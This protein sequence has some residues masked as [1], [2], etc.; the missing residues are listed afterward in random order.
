MFVAATLRLV[1]I[2]DFL[3]QSPARNKEVEG[4]FEGLLGIVEE[5]VEA[6][7][8]GGSQGARRVYQAGKGHRHNL[9]GGIDKGQLVHVVGIG[10]VQGIIALDAAAEASDAAQIGLHV[11]APLGLRPARPTQLKTNRG[12][13]GEGRGTTGGRGVQLIA[14][15][16][17]TNAVVVHLVKII[18]A[19]SCG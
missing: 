18:V 13:G 19:I 2:V 14:S 11:R 17:R 1:R 15:C 3:I 9:I 16:I 6:I 7:P 10:I 5:C 12:V 8:T 4:L